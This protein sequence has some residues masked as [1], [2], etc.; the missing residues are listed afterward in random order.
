MTKNTGVLLHISSLPGVYP[1]GDF[2]PTAYALADILAEQKIKYWQLLPLGPADPEYFYSPYTMFSSFALGELYASLELLVERELLTPEEAA[3]CPS[4]A[5]DYPQAEKLK[6]DLLRRAYARFRPDADYDRFR[7]EQSF[8]LEAYAEFQAL[9]RAAGRPWT[10]W[11][12]DKPDRA[13]VEYEMFVQYILFAQWQTLKQ[14]ANNKGIK[15]IGDLPLFTA[16]NSADVW[17]FPRY[18]KLRSDKSMAVTAG[19][20]PDYFNAQGQ[21]WQLPLYNWDALQE[22]DFS[23]WRSRIWSAL[24]KYDLLR[25]DH[26]RGLEACYEIPGGDPHGLNG[27]WVKTPGAELLAAVK[28]DFPQMPLIAEDLGVITPEVRRLRADFGLPGMR[29]GLLDFIDYPRLR[30]QSEHNIKQHAPD[31]ILYSTTHDFD[32]VLGWYA[33]A[34]PEAREYFHREIG[35]PRPEN[36][37]RYWLSSP[38]DTVIFPAQDILGLGSAARLN[39]PGTSGA[40]RNWVW[41]LQAEEPLKLNIVNPF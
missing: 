1:V 14:Y 3:P 20:P 9:R 4:V 32:T 35:E 19:V 17:A 16:H 10:Q 37:L 34:P 39:F 30:G 23:W 40:G 25:L 13:L 24:Q 31:S 29:V 21:V 2:G 27:R 8:W 12:T 28:K 26:F 36:Y 18:F 11:R 33:T 38:A 22:D 6:N 7:Q 15:I 5:A 41:R